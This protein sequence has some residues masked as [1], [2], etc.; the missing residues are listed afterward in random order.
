MNPLFTEVALKS[1]L[2]LTAAAT[3]NVLVYRRTSAATR[4]LVWTF[5]VAGLLLLPIFSAALPRWEVA[6]HV[7]APNVPAAAPDDPTGRTEVS[8]A[9]AVGGGGVPSPTAATA[10]EGTP[11]PAIASHVPWATMLPVLYAVG[12]FLLVGRLV[13]ERW[14]VQRLARHATEVSDP[15]WTRLLF[16]C[17][18]RI[19]VQRPVR[20]LRSRERAMPMALGTRLPAILLPAFADTWE[21]DRRRAVLLH[22][23]AHVVRHDCLTQ[24]LAAIVC[25]FYWV[26]PGVWWVARRLR[27]E[28]ELACDDRVLAAGTHPRDYAGHLLELAYSFGG[29]RAPALAVSM[30]RPGQLEGRLRAVLDAARNRTT[31][32]LHTRLSVMAIAVAVLIPL[33]AASARVVPAALAISKRPAVEFAQADAATAAVAE[34]RLPGTWSIRSSQTARF[35]H[36]RLTESSD[37]SYGS[38]ISIERLEGLSPAVLAGGGGVVQFSLRRDAGTMAFEGTFRSGV[39]AGTYTF[40]PS[41]SFSAELAKRGF[42]QPAST[43]QY[44]LAR[45]DIGFAFLDELTAQGY[46]RP[47]LAQLVQSALHGV[48]L[49]YLQDMGRLGYRLGFVQALIAQRDHGV[50]PQFVRELRAQGLTGLSSDDLLRAR[51]HGVSAEYVRE[52]GALGYQNLS[53]DE[54]VRLRNNGVSAEYVRELEALGYRNLSRDEVIRLRN[55]GVSA[56]YVRELGALGY[57]N[58]SRDEVIRLRNHGVDAEYVRQL[59]TLGYDRLSIDE[60]V[61]LR[62]RGVTPEGIRIANLRAGMRLLLDRLKA[63]AAAGGLL[64]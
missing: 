56:E 5:A 38:T 37:S 24:M 29:H 14:M 33:A 30:A 28:R 59:K 9:V 27:I 11:P 49:D 35:V 48:D 36:L 45:D 34:P 54:L 7:A 19:G 3:M 21:E 31:P 58:L 47:D 50:S 55:N 52:L 8:D 41:A 17:S 2:L 63:L 46:A 53:L 15:E 44:M 61:D 64:K 26:H 40:T 25:T 62:N 16:E 6:I 13:A 20:L 10:V 57:R 1:S 22:E 4:H 39:G 42:A 60:L 18:R 51:N 23:L 12:V 43:D 32:G